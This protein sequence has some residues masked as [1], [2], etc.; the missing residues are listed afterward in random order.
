MSDMV[1][2]TKGN[3]ASGIRIYEAVRKFLDDQSD[4][5][6]WGTYELADAVG[7]SYTHLGRYIG[8]MPELALYSAQQPGA[9]NIRVFGS[10]EAIA[11]LH[12]SV[13]GVQQGAEANA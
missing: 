7:Y 11:R 8:R 6:Y 9:R 2:H 1:F 10:R 13:N 4:N 12:A 3:K 5:E